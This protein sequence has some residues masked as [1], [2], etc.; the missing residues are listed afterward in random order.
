[1][2]LPANI[3]DTTQAHLQALINEGVQEGP[4][5]DFK[6]ELP[7]TWSAEAKRDFL[8][9][10]TA[11]A[12]SGGG[13]LIYGMEE[14]DAV[15]AA[16]VPA[17]RDNWDE[18]IQRLQNMLHDG[19][20]P[21]A[22]GI[23][24]Q[25]VDVALDQAK[26]VVLVVSVPQ[27]W[28]GPHRLKAN[29]HFYVRD[30]SSNRP[31]DV[32][33]LRSLFLRSDAVGQRIRDFRSERLGR[34]LAGETPVKLES[35]P[36]LVVHFVPTQTALALTQVD[37]TQYVPPGTCHLPRLGP[38]TGYSTR[39]NLDGAVLAGMPIS[40]GKSKTYTVLFRNA[41][42]EGVVTLNWPEGR[43]RAV[44]PSL[45]F[46]NWAIA[47]LKDTRAELTRQGVGAEVIAMMSLLHSHSVEM[48]LDQ[49]SGGYSADQ[50]VFDR[51]L[52]CLP[53]VLISGNEPEELAL[54]PVFD[55]MWQAAG[56]A[57]S[58]NY[59]VNGSRLPR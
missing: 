29:Q 11:F 14:H 16:L 28:V 48:G 54:R 20:E 43:S 57:R 25:R 15:A 7:D 53:D 24:I 19:V 27:S 39:I 38:V 35:G 13:H 22:I 31:L 21:S 36:A 50:G 32:P 47:F 34:I 45:A 44:L 59:H 30:G 26:G 4:H 58:F 12:N 42:V 33:G 10:V 49:F 55:L 5:L 40:D 8:A 52:V 51:D 3:A 6:R 23:R 2:A 56:F 46:E 1:M 37:V 18:A 17:Q 9:D 41:D